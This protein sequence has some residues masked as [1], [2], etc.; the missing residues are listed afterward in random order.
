MHLLFMLESFDRR[1]FARCEDAE[2]KNYSFEVEFSFRI[3]QIFPITL[4]GFILGM[5]QNKV[6]HNY[7]LQHYFDY[8]VCLSIRPSVHPFVCPLQKRFSLLKTQA[9][10][11]FSPMLLEDAQQTVNLKRLTKRGNANSSGNNGT[12]IWF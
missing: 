6:F 9:E 1:S 10:D 4:R 2:T 8:H 7:S 5:L 3:F 11:F 12:N